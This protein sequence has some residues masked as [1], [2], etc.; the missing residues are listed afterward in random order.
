MKI[1]LLGPAYPYRGGPATFNDR[2]A[3]QFS[4]EGHDIEV[5]TFLL[6]YPGILFPGKTQYNDGPPPEGVRIE[7]L[8]NSVNPFNWIS[9]G[10]KIKKLNC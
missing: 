5:V 4:A 10:R 7:R 8:V 1:I 9:T 3:R 2:L 6:Q